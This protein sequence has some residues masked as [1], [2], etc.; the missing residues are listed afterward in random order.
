MK[1]LFAIA[2]TVFCVVYGQLMTKWRIGS[3]GSSLTESRGLTGRLL[4]YLT[5]PL[6]LSAYISAFLASIAWVFVVEKYDISTAF[7][8]YIGL[9]T[10]FVSLGG[11]LFF[12]EGFNLQKFIAICLIVAGVIIATRA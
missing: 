10:V 12:H 11:T 2:P 8:V 4:V 1:M 9:I 5:D 7:P 6:I 3:L